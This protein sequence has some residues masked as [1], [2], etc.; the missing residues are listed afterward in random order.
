[1]QHDSGVKKYGLSNFITM[2]K[3]RLQCNTDTLY[4]DHLQA[5]YELKEGD[6]AYIYG[7]FSLADN[8][9]G[10]AICRY[11]VKD[12]QNVF[13]SSELYRMGSGGQMEK[14]PATPFIQRITRS[15]VSYI[16]C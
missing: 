6:D 10:S 8:D 1:M 11:R 16:Y 15:S 4:F 5:T 3:T 2:L 9:M 12:I 7:V 13:G 14:K